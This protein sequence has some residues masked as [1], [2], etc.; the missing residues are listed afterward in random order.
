VVADEAVQPAPPTGGRRGRGRAGRLGFERVQTCSTSS[1]SACGPV[2]SGRK[3]GSSNGT[4]T[5]RSGAAR[6]GEPPVV[7]SGP[8]FLLGDR[9]AEDDLPG[10]S[11]VPPPASRGVTAGVNA[12]TGRC[13]GRAGTATGGGRSGAASPASCVTPVGRVRS[14]EACC[15]LPSEELLSVERPHPGEDDVGHP[16]ASSLRTPAAFVAAGAM[17]GRR[18]CVGARGAG[19]ATSR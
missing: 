8:T 4:S 10:D 2:R 14:Q 16:T 12:R 7:S 5:L 6:R 3:G 19:S 9:L 18:R 1:G 15:Q 17:K 11:N 13:Q